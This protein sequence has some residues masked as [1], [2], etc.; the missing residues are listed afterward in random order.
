[1]VVP[2]TSKA[3]DPPDLTPEDLPWYGWVCAKTWLTTFIGIAS[4]IWA[5]PVVHAIGEVGGKTVKVF[6]AALTLLWAL[7]LLLMAVHL[8]HLWAFYPRHA[9]PTRGA[10]GKV[11][12]LWMELYYSVAGRL[13]VAAAAIAI[14][15]LA[16]RLT[17][18]ENGNAVL[19]TAVGGLMGVTALADLFGD[20]NRKR[21]QL[22]AWWKQN[23]PEHHAQVASDAMFMW[24]GTGI[25]SVAVIVVTIKPQWNWGVG[26]PALLIYVALVI[27]SGK[28]KLP[29]TRPRP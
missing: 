1:M 14:M 13:N 6:P 22:D 7:V 4:A 29:I 24:W 26:I 21:A 20:R 11:L 12:E 25:M 8:R 17:P 5:A 27:I 2:A 10:S 23:A 19:L 18:E 16:A 15:F 28:R 3:G 9:R